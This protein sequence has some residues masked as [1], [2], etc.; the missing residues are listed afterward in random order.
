M[1][2]IEFVYLY[3]HVMF[4]LSVSVKWLAVKTASEMTYRPTVSSGALTLL[5]LQL[6]VKRAATLCEVGKNNV[7]HQAIKLLLSYW[8]NKASSFI[9][10]HSQD[11]MTR[12]GYEKM[13]KNF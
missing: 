9:A 8:A 3:F 5:Q 11:K 13:L 7:N 2:C 10:V 4:C 12:R 6:Q 1:I